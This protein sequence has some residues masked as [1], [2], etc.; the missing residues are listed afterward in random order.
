MCG[1]RALQLLLHVVCRLVLCVSLWVSDWLAQR[2][3]FR[4]TTSE[5]N[6]YKCLP[7]LHMSDVQFS[8]SFSSSS[9]VLGR[10]L[11]PFSSKN[12][13]EIDRQSRCLIWILVRQ[14]PVPIFIAIYTISVVV[15]MRCEW[16]GVCVCVHGLFCV[17]EKFVRQKVTHLDIRSEFNDSIRR[18]N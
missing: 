17:L 1:F 11:W 13:E 12:G 2:I 15:I 4:C 16:L 14:N 9:M 8:L 5:R 18:S 3:G 6:I 10:L 7:P